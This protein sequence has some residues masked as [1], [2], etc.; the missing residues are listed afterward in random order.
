MPSYQKMIVVGH[1][2]RD[3][4]VRYIQSGTAVCNFSVAV[5]DKYKDKETTTWFAVTVWGKLAESCGEYLKKGR[6]VL[7]EGKVDLETYDAKD[8]T[9]RS[10]LRL[11]ASN[12]RFMGGGSS[13]GD[14]GRENARHER[15]VADE[16][17]PF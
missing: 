6:L 8:G 5:T 15:A 14:G 7:I 16:E 13:S 10:Q 4:E 12:V 1:L 17:I 11:T 9:K 3:P 2:G